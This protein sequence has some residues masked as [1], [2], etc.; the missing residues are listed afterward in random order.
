M[1]TTLKEQAWQSGLVLSDE[2]AEWDEN[3]WPDL[4][5]GA[6]EYHASVV[7]GHHETDNDNNHKRQTVVVLGGYKQGQYGVNSVLV[8]NLAE[9]NKQWREG[10]PMNKARYGHAAVACNRGVYVMGGYNGEALDC[11]ER[12]DANNL[13]PP[14]RSIV[15]GQH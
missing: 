10:P 2:T 6:R 11:I 7:I 12:I 15:I 9:S 1:T 3:D 8:L 5:G 13:L 4:M 14:R